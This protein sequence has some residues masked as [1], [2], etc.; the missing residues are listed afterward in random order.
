MRKIDE[1]DRYFRRPNALKTAS[2]T[3]PNRFYRCGGSGG[4]GT[5]FVGANRRLSA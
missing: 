2:P 3:L 5:Q 1:V 4:R